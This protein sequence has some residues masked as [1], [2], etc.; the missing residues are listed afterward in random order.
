[1]LKVTFFS[2]LI[3][4]SLLFQACSSDKKENKEGAHLKTKQVAT[5]QLTL[6]TTQNKPLILEK[7]ANGFTLKNE[8]AKIL[9]ID[10]FATWCPPCQNEASVLSKISKKYGNKVKII[11]VTIEENIP[12][13]KLENFKTT[14]G[15]NY[16]LVNSN[17]N[18]VLI[19]TIADNLKLGRNFGIPLLALYKDG[20]LIQYYQGAT[21][22]EFIISDIN[23]ALGK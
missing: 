3:A 19:D 21:E 14:Y 8:K 4:F 15:A 5:N 10:V 20:K 16:T 2:S 11:G 7:T 23:K 22:E 12:N 6:T 9:L 13:T 18:R 17:Q 1:M